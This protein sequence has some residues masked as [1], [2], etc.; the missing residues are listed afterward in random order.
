VFKSAPADWDG[1]GSGELVRGRQHH[2]PV[3]G[4]V[5]DVRQIRERVDFV[6]FTRL[7]E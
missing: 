3:A 1:A 2:D 5:E 6:G 7:N 4:V